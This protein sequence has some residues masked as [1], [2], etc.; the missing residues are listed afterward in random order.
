MAGKR[1]KPA[2]EKVLTG[3]VGT[4]RDGSRVKIAEKD[5]S[6]GKKSKD[7]PKRKSA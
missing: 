2:F 3:G 6:E 5:I 7:T 4:R 1:K